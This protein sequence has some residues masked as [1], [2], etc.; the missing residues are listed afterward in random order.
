M[1]AAAVRAKVILLLVA[2]MSAEQRTTLPPS[3]FRH[4]ADA[5]VCRRSYLIVFVRKQY[6]E[7][8]RFK[9][10]AT[11]AAPLV[12]AMAQAVSRRPLTAEARFQ[13]RPV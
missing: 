6:H 4:P 8:G 5:T 10:V 9:A 1:L 11:Y 2:T 3:L 12:R 13:S 7:Q